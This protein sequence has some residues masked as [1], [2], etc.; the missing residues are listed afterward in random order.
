MTK[1]GTTYWIDF[2]DKKLPTIGDK[3]YCNYLDAPTEKC[4][5]LEYNGNEVHL[6]VIGVVGFE[7][8]Q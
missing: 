4:K 5:V 8:E 1:I 2:K 7:G 3:I 6:E